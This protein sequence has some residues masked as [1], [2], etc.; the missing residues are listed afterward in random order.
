MT[1]RS[2]ILSVIILGVAVFSF[3]PLWGRQSI[4]PEG[5]KSE[6]KFALVCE[7]LDHYRN[8]LLAVDSQTAADTI[9]MAKEQ[10]FR[11]IKGSDAILRSL[12][13]DEEF[14]ISCDDGVYSTQWR[15]DGRIVVSCKFPSRVDLLSFSN[16]IQLEDKM[17]RLLEGYTAVRRTDKVPTIPTSRL[18]KVEYSPFYVRDLGYY[19]TPRLSHQVVYEPLEGKMEKSELVVNHAA[20]PL[21][22]VSNYML[23]GFS[24]SPIEIRV[25]VSR[26]GYQNASVS[27]SLA[28]LFEKLS[29]E[30]SVPYWGVD[31]FDGKIVKGLYLWLNQPGGFAHVLTVDIPI[32]GLSSSTKAKAKMNCYVRLDNLKYLFE[33]F[34]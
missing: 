7:F 19:I 13:G 33:E 1:L 16:K 5:V 15:R 8:L 23:T 27:L 17:I 11:Y 25:D 2:K 30:G 12:K 9:R 14:S 28:E 26:Y 18:K 32:A 3:Y 6:P 4:V 24:P 31:E 29:S 20:Y 22:C 34:K 10:G 21:E